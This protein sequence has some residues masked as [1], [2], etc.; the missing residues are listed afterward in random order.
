MTAGVAGVAGVAGGG[1]ARNECLAKI[2]EQDLQSL[3]GMSVEQLR[4]HLRARGVSDNELL[5]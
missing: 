5:R 1:G 3:Q 4:Q 2:K